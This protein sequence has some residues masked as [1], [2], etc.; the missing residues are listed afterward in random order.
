MPFVGAFL[1]WYFTNLFQLDRLF[2]TYESENAVFYLI[3]VLYLLGLIF[4]WCG[5][6]EI[7]FQYKNGNARI[8]R[9]LSIFRVYLLISA[10]FLIILWPGT[11]AWDDIWTLLSERKYHLLHSAVRNG[12]RCV[13]ERTLCEAKRTPRNTKISSY[14][15]GLITTV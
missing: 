2:F 10:V 8:K 1:Q 13:S 12:R 7:Y 14:T 5:C 6:S 15:F 9:G 4:I 3:K 11:W